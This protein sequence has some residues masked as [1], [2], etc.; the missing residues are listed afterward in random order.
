MTGGHTAR[1]RASAL[2]AAV[3]LTV[4]IGLPATAVHAGALTPPSSPRS[5]T[6]TPG[7]KV[8]QMTLGWLAPSTGTATS[9]KYDVSTD[10]GAYSA[11]S[12]PTGIVAT[13]GAYT[14]SAACV[15]T[16][17]TCAFRLYALNS[18]GSSPASNVATSGWSVPGAP[19]MTTV[20]AGPTVGSMNVSWTTP[21]NTGGQT[22]TSL[23]YQVRI[24]N[25]PGTWQSG[26]VP[27]AA[28]V[29]TANLPCPDANSNGGCDYA[30]AAVNAVGP[31]AWSAT[32]T[33]AWEVPTAP[34]NLRTTSLLG[35]NVKV[36]WGVPANSGGLAVTAYEY[37][38]GIDGGAF[39]VST[40]LPA[41]PLTA[42]VPLCGGTSTCG[43]RIRAV[44]AHGTGAWSNT[45]TVPVSAPGTVASL[46]AAVA[47]ND[48]GAGNSQVTV[49]WGPPT[50]GG[51][52][53]SYDVQ[54]CSGNCVSTSTYWNT[55][56][57]TT[58]GNVTSWSPVCGEV[59]T[60]S[61]RVRATNTLG[62]SSWTF[63]QVSPYAP[64]GVSA[65]AGPALGQVTVRFN[66]PAESGATG[67]GA[68]ARRRVL[69]V[70]RGR[71]R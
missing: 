10:G 15:A 32:G 36:A 19:M 33:G 51:P 71:Y 67:P 56:T 63:V 44:N 61:Y 30:I 54:Q 28:T 4:G 43:Y 23:I 2:L 68:S 47:S 70:E 11:L 25:P 40:P 53:T 27:G 37:Q 62:Q 20:S 16:A 49:T 22:I 69:R 12:A 46:V 26:A 21:T 59:V 18:G 7:P 66:G 60:C 35:N 29:R 55:A 34:S 45:L 41:S 6:A 24:S 42:S 48:F 31:G 65:T 64:T 39:G 8:G 9:W 1:R 50:R 5:V 3:S 14:G 38:V 58:V 17:T 13:A 57:V 52:A